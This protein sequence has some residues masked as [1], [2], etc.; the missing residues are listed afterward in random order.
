MY[1]CIRF[2]VLELTSIAVCHRF[3][4]RAWYEH[5]SKLIPLPADGADT[6]QELAPGEAIVFAAQPGVRTGRARGDGDGSADG[7]D[8]SDHAA[9]G[10]VMVPSMMRV[11]MRKRLTADGG[12]SRT[13]HPRGARNAAHF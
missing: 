1:A 12:A 10:A 5:L 13:N 3:H 8:A 4:S 9:D 11:Q 7:G 2:K 6:V